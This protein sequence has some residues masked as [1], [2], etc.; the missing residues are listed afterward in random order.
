MASELTSPIF[1]LP[2]RS[3]FSAM[4]NDLIDWDRPV[5]H[6]VHIKVQHSP[7]TECLHL[8]KK[9]VLGYSHCNTCWA[10]TD[11]K[12]NWFGG[13]YADHAPCTLNPYEGDCYD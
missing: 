2:V 12:G 8:N 4:F 5:A 10:Q 13:I 3:K 6:R 9:Y 1:R 7:K 11:A